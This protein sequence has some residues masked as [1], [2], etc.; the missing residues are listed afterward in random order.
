MF[1]GFETDYVL[2]ETVAKVYRRDVIAKELELSEAQM[3]EWTI[4][5]GNYYIREEMDVGFDNLP[6]PL[7]SGIDRLRIM[8]KE[9]GSDFRCSN[10]DNNLQRAINYSRS[11]YNLEDASRTPSQALQ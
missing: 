3:I 10:S 1:D 6:L 8:V 5:L 9:L 4:L 2:K 11:Y 7:P